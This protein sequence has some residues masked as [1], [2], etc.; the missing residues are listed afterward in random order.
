MSDQPLLTVIVP[1]YNVEKYINKCVSSI[2]SQS[3]P[4]LEILLINDGS[5][6]ETGAIC[7][8]WQDR[9]QRIRVIHKQNEGLSYARK[10]GIENMTADYVAFVDADDWIDTNMYADMMSAMI[11]TDSDIAQCAYCEIFEDGRMKHHG[12]ERNAA[13]IEVIGREEGVFLILKAEKWQSFVWNKIFKKQLF[14]HIVFPKGRVFEDIPIMHSLF[15][16]AS[17]SVYL[18]A[19]YYVYF[20]RSGSITL[21]KDIASIMKNAYDAYQAFY[22][23]YCF[24][25]QHPEYHSCLALAKINAFSRGMRLLRKSIQYPQ[26]FPEYYSDSLMKQLHTI[27]FI[28][29]NIYK[30]VF[31]PLMKMEFFV[32]KICPAYYKRLIM[33]Y[34]NSAL[35]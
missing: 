15:H 3:Y 30:K 21:S 8:T 29:K 18:S 17:L 25:E 16:H 34:A 27:Q 33:L 20:R 4:H 2:V 35:V 13:S 23:R 22:E 28:R 10:T 1:C 5:T 24:V 32:F 7:G 19:E 14:D 11:S 31:S 6:D 26:Y 9:D 12:T